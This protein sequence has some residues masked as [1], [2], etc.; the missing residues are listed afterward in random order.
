MRHEPVGTGQMA[1]C[2]RLHLDA[3]GGGPD[4]LV[5]KLSVPGTGG[6]PM[7]ANA[8]RTEVAFYAEVA[9]TVAARTP[10]CHHHA[11]TDDHARFT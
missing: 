11:I 5:A 4:T 9:P 8:Y 10:A 1:A 3:T 7:V 2:H 6:N